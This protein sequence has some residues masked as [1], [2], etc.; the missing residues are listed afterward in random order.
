MLQASFFFFFHFLTKLPHFLSF[1]HLVIIFRYHHLHVLAFGKIS[2]GYL[3]SLPLLHRYSCLHSTD[4]LHFHFF[5]Q[6]PSDILHFHF[7]SFAARFTRFIR[8]FPFKLSYLCCTLP[9]ISA[10][11]TSSQLWSNLPPGGEENVTLQRKMIFLSFQ[12]RGF[13]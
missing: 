9:Q 11:K 12:L 1:F 8:Y 10:C 7:L 6:I 4:I 13:F 3:S 2:P 5:G